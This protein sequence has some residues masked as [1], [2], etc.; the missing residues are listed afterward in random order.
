MTHQAIK[1]DEYRH[2]FR[3]D[4]AFAEFAELLRGAMAA[5][6]RPIVANGNMI[7]TVLSAAG[8]KSVLGD[9]ILRRIERNPEVID[10]LL[11]RLD[12]EE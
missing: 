9:R 10:E 2:L 11:N 7:G 3:D 8:S 6:F 4:A 12:E 1:L 5:D